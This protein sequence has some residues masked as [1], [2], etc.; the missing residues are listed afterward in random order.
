MSKISKER[1]A[2]F[3]FQLVK[4]MYRGEVKLLSLRRKCSAIDTEEHEARLPI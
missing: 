4:A 1:M 3:K 2:R